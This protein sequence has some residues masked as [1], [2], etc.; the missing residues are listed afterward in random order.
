MT[1]QPQPTELDGKCCISRLI[2]MSIKHD[3]NTGL[4]KFFLDV[5][6]NAM[7]REDCGNKSI[8][9][10]NQASDT[11]AFF[12]SYTT[13]TCGLCDTSCA[14][15]ALTSRSTQSQRGTNGLP[16]VFRKLR[17]LMNETCHD[18]GDL[19]V[20]ASAR[21]KIGPNT[22]TGDDLTEDILDELKTLFPELKDIDFGCGE[23]AESGV[24][25]CGSNPGPQ[26]GGISPKQK[27]RY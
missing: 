26:Y 19:E 25:A 16:P 10:D 5:I 21:A 1:P 3:P 18:Y 24:C 6:L 17:D 15:D 7:C 8:I 12:K 13:Q 2:R 9:C 20:P 22:T 11:T 14:T 27:E 4:F 23:V